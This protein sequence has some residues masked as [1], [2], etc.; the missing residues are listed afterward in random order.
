MGRGSK[1]ILS[2]LVILGYGKA[3]VAFGGQ[4]KKLLVNII[5]KLCNFLFHPVNIF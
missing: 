4:N 5:F 3:T 1:K 2:V